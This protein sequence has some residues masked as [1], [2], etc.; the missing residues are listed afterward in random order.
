[1]VAHLTVIMYSVTSVIRCNSSFF[2]TSSYTMW[3]IFKG[4]YFHN[5]LNE[6]WRKQDCFFIEQSTKRPHWRKKWR[7]P[8]MLG[9]LRVTS[10]GNYSRSQA[11]QKNWTSFL[12]FLWGS[13]NQKGRGPWNKD[14]EQFKKPS[15][16]RFK[17]LESTD[18]GAYFLLPSH[19]HKQKG[20]L[21]CVKMLPQSGFALHNRKSRKAF[22]YTGAKL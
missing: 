20:H 15:L 18:R 3:S 14:L 1:M 2:Y 5:Y 6:W 10:A 19:V 13:K 21:L 11:G 7:P 9:K 12:I 8:N 22:C 4:L 16:K 17:T